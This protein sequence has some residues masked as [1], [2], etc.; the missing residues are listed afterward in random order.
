MMSQGQGTYGSQVSY[1]PSTKNATHGLRIRQVGYKNDTDTANGVMQ[2]QTY[3][4][5][6]TSKAV[7][8]PSKP[9][10]THAKQWLFWLLRSPA[11][12]T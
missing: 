4:L 7:K 12:A 8:Q 9:Q 5:Q 11:T 2:L 1:A 6:H 10:S 3:A